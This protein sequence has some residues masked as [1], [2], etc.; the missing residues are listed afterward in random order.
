MKSF[1]YHIQINVS[2]REASFGFYKELLSFFGYKILYEGSEDLGMSNKT[3]DIWLMVSPEKFKDN[4]FHRKRVGMNHLAFGVE[5]KK[6]VDRFIKEFLNVKGIKP[7][8]DSPRA[9]PEYEDG[10]YAV[11]FEDPDR[12][13]LEVTFKPGFGE[14]MKFE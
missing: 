1:V 8:Y 11:F 7:L 5:T 2:N 10:Y 14:R 9:Y 6:E 13:K 12:I 4:G 3:T